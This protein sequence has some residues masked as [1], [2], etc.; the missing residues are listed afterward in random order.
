LS[1]CG[2]FDGICLPALESSFVPWQPPRA[3]PNPMHDA[4]PFWLITVFQTLVIA[5]IAYVV[6]VFIELVLSR[7]ALMPHG[8]LWVPAFQGP[9]LF[10]M[11]VACVVFLSIPYWMKEWD[12]GLRTFSMFS[13]VML[14]AIAVLAQT[15]QF[16]VD[17]PLNYLTVHVLVPAKQKLGI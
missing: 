2:D 4:K 17:G 5:C 3:R 8:P 6:A 1:H 11:T 16:D 10:V 13:S 15:G 9:F 7:V 14:M 12:P